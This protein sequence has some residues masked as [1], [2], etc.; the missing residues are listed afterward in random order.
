MQYGRFV[1]VKSLE[2][3]EGYVRFYFHANPEDRDVVEIEA[4]DGS[5]VVFVRVKKEHLEKVLGGAF[6]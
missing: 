6:D 4:S 1:E 2:D 5:E 3:A